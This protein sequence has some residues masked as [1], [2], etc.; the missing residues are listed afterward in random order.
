MADRTVKVTLQAQVA[1]YVAGM[2]KAASATRKT[3]SEAEKLAQK[4]EAFELL[5][6]TALVMGSVIAVGVGLAIA[7]AAEFDQALS[8]VNAVMQ[9]TTGNQKLLRQAALDFGASSV[10]TATES[11]NA[12]EELGKAGLTTAD[13]L[14]GGLAG[15][16]ALASAGQLEIARAAEIAATTLQQFGLD[17]SQASRVADTLAA[18][19]GKAL[20]SV[21]DLAQGL[22][23]VGP[24]AA[25][26]GISLE[27]TTGVLALFAQQG[28]I[29]EQA[30]TSLRGMLSSLTSPS[31]LARKEIER[32]GITLH[33]QQGAFL[34]LD[35]VAGQ[36]SDAFSTATDEERD[37]SLGMIFGNQ[38]VT[39]ARVLF[40]AGAEG[41]AEWTDAV[42]DSGFAAR[43]AADRLNNLMGDLEKLGGAFDTALITTGSAANEVLRFMA[44]ALTN[45]IDLYNAAPEP[46][47]A[48]ALAVGVVTSAVL[49]SGG[50]FLLAVPKVAQ[51]NAALL[52]MGTTAQRTGRILALSAGPVSIAFAV[53]GTALAIFAGQQAE[54]AA[55]TQTLTD[56]LDANT[57]AFTKNTRQHVINLLEKSGTLKIAKLMGI[58]L[59]VM[60]DAALGE[61]DAIQ[62]VNDKLAEQRAQNTGFG[63]E[64]ALV[65]Q[66]YKGIEDAISGTSGKLAE[67][68]EKWR[69]NTE[70]MESGT[71]ATD[72]NADATRSA[73]DAYLD[74]SDEAAGL[75]DTLDTLLAKV[76]ESN[77][78][79]Q[80]AVSANATYRQSL[81]DIAA[82]V[83][84][85]KD[86]YEEANKTLDGF[87]LSLDES[88]VAG[89]ANAASLAGIA[90]SA[91]DAALAQ[92]EVDKTTMSA[93]DATDK[94][95]ATLGLSREE[96]RL[97]AEA[98]GFS[99]DQ[100]QILLDKVF[101]MPTERETKLLVETATADEEVERF[102]RRLDSIPPNKTVTITANL[103]ATGDVRLGSGLLE[104]AGGVMD[105]YASGGM[106]ENHVAQIAPA[107]SWRVWGEPET[108]GESYIPLATSKRARSLDIWAETGSRLGVPG[109]ANGVIVPQF[110]QSAPRFA[111]PVVQQSTTVQ[112]VTEVINLQVE[113][114]TLAQTIREYDRGLK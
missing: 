68:R 9:E 38:Q 112:R 31:S 42:Q 100:V 87:T 55:E 72:I 73:A 41:V 97:Q 47:K 79:N 94:Y 1:G 101:A 89:S 37:M 35:N 109:F 80:D 70:A 12:I 106:R 46:V 34:G 61:A 24:V 111:A 64:S 51:F 58:S 99:A 83:Q 13:I 36:L 54:A 20:G 25:S 107:G 69:L 39:A 48:V 56:S 10:F 77:G 90:Q 71:T 113:G 19:A 76:D 105:F 75:T 50:V 86:A 114:R 43:V 29:G 44:Q 85:Q 110:V 60:T 63:S 27:E 62:I 2:E 26:M 28:I 93:K 33:D 57:G 8:N 78:V 52:T 81:A 40:Q 59:G 21:E 4:K 23:F 11:A 3:G 67:A 74:A 53:A 30:G 7:K 16:L 104:A 18:G 84:R 32:L 14:S 17:G 22:K 91:Q 49:L 88:T 82:D 92:F 102:K 95:I 45:L 96:L 108:G 65:Q 98:N 15:S 103:R 5:G 66:S 6:R